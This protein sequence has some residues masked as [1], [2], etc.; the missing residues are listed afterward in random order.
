M[1]TAALVPE[2]GEKINPGG[3][4]AKWVPQP[5][6]FM[7]D[8]RTYFCE[9]WCREKT[10]CRHDGAKSRSSTPLQSNITSKHRWNTREAKMHNL[11]PFCIGML[12]MLIIV[13]NKSFRDEPEV[14]F[15]DFI[16]RLTLKK[17]IRI[18]SILIFT[19][20]F[21][22][23]LPLDLAILYAGDVLVYFE[24]FTAVSFLAAQ[25]RARTTWYIIRRLAE[26]S[27]RAL[28]K[29]FVATAQ[30]CV[31]H[32]RHAIRAQRRRHSASISKKSDE[33]SDPVRW[34][35]PA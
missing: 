24:V 3:A 28:T 32:Y 17:A 15:V 20:A 13:L 6:T 16:K 1:G 22:Y 35:L 33:E 12:F 9:T 30:K 2:P 34:G 10:C 19:F 23:T 21:I 11:A 5:D 27:L 14:T 26:D 31:S 7:I 4:E 8:F 18:L 29:L 25:A